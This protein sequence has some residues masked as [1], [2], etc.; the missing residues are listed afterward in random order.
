MLQIRLNISFV[1][2]ILKSS[3]SDYLLTFLT[4]PK[5]HDMICKLSFALFI[6]KTIVTMPREVKSVNSGGPWNCYDGIH[7]QHI[8]RKWWQWGKRPF[9]CKFS[10]KVVKKKDGRQMK[11]CLRKKYF[12]FDEYHFTHHI[13]TFTSS[14]ALQSV[15][16]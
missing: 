5:V 14:A 2:F 1:Y 8:N 4:P 15:S 12:R 10:T 11:P 3:T 7:L 16:L 13:T 9:L 6:I